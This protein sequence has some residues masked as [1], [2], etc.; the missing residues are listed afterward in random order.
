MKRLTLICCMILFTI[1]M[2]GCSTS[3]NNDKKYSMNAT[4]SYGAVDDSLDKAK[5]TYELSISGKKNDID[6]IVAQEPL[7]NM[8]YINL[9]LENGPHSLQMKGEDKPYIEVSGSFVFDTA[10]KSKVEIEDMDLFQGIKIIDKDN[11]EYVLKFS[12]R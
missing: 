2:F 10:G 9:M 6:N 8:E 11:N 4:I 12:K 7:I 5:I 1:I 3:S